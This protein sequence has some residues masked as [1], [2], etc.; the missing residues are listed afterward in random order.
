MKVDTKGS[1]DFASELAL[2]EPER[3]ALLCVQEVPWAFLR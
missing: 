2:T 3:Q 1:H